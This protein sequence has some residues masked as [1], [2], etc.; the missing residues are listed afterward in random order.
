MVLNILTTK[1]VQVFLELPV[2]SYGRCCS[3]HA[4]HS[5]DLYLYLGGVSVKKTTTKKPPGYVHEPKTYLLLIIQNI[6]LYWK[7]WGQ[8]YW[9][10]N[11]GD[12]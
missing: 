4:T 11:G 6:S 5:S 10:A 8:E 12:V 9:T 2:Y 7:M 1:V 3:K